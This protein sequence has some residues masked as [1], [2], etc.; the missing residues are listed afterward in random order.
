VIN[1]FLIFLSAITNENLSVWLGNNLC[2]LRAEV[3][4]DNG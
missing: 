3:T 2:L 4:I 1:N